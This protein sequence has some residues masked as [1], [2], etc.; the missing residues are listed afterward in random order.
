MIF[1][2]QEYWFVYLSVFGSHYAGFVRGGLR[3]FRR[4]DIA[5]VRG[6]T[7]YIR[8]AQDIGRYPSAGCALFSVPEKDGRRV[9]STLASN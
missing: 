8:A 2:E 5:A 4:P 9:S 3:T 6:V 1:S 7:E